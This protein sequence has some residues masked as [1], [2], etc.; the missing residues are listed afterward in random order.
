LALYYL[1]V[2]VIQ[3]PWQLV[4]LQ[5]LNA[6]F[7]ATVAGVGLTDFQD[8]FPSPGLASGLFTNTRRVGAVLSGLLITASA[9]FP[10]AYRAVYGAAAILVVLVLVGYSATFFI[11]SH[12]RIERRGALASPQS[13]AGTDSRTP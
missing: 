11:S 8:I 9:S 13:K 4:A 5:P 1:L 6:W 10:D 7:F 12:D 2:A 3:A